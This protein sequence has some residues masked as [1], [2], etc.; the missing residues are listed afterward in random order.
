MNRCIMQSDT[1]LCEK[2]DSEVS[3][4]AERCPN[5]G[6]A[7]QAKGRT[8][9]KLFFVFGMLLT[10]SVIGAPVGIPMLL[11]YWFADRQVSGKTV[12]SS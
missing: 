2:C 12:V 11:L 1:G 4:N 5:C 3:T 6:Y 9:R 8:V 7:P 10:L